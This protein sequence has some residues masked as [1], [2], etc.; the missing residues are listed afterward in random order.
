MLRATLK[1]LLAR[2][3]RLVL[4]MLAVVVGVSFVTGTLVLTDTLNRTFDTLFADINKNVS[5]A[6]RAVNQIDPSSD[7]GRPPL[8]ATVLP[9]LARVDGVR[10]AVGSVSGQAVLVDPR[11]GK[12]AD[13][14]GAPGIGTNWTGGQPTA[15]EQ[16]AE[17]R[18][19]GPGEIV[20]DRAT[21]RSMHLAL[22]TRIV[23]QTK[24]PPGTYTLV[25]TFRV[26]GQDSVGGAAVT[27]FDTATAQRVL[28]APN[29][30]SAVH[31]A[32]APGIG[33]EQLRA[34]VAAVL[35]GGVEAITGK[36][37]A[38]ENAGAVQQAIRGFSTFLLIFAA[39]SVFVGAFIIFNTFTMLVAQRVRELA[40]LRAIG[41]SR[42]QVQLSLQVEAAMVGF[43]G[44]TAGLVVGAGLALLLRAAVG[45]FG[46]SLPGGSL[47]FSPR[48]IVVAY[49][50]GVVIT[51]VAAFVPARKAASV[52]PV[53]AMRETYVLP[54]RSLRLRAISGFAL[55]TL[56]VLLLVLGTA[57]AG[58]SGATSVGVGA[59]AI[60]LGVA[61]LSPL[62]SGPV[63]RVLGTPF[64]SMFGTTGRLGRENAMR[65][66]RRTAST[67]SALMIGLAL[68]SA[69]AILGQ[70]IKESVRATVTDSLGAD[71]YLSA[72][73]F[74]QG[75]SG[76]VAR[77][78]AG[79][80]G[81]DTATGL[82][83]GLAKVDGSS[84]QLLAGDPAGL[85]KVLAIKKV[86]GDIHALGDRTILVE[87]GVA[88]DHHFT[89]GQKIRVAF[90]DG[91]EDLTLVGTY[92]K[93]QVA[94]SWIISTAQYARHTPDDLDLFVLVKRAD[95]A[96]P[97]AV[98]AQIDAVVKPFATVE[99]RDQS[100]FV[101][102][103]EK[104]VDQL[105]GFIYVLLALAVV[106]ALF[107]I[108]N[109]LALSVIERTREIGLLRAVGMSRGQMRA[110]VVMESTIISVFGAV[111]GVAVGSVFGWA[112][113]RALEGQGI[114]AFAYPASTII[115]VILIGVLLGILAAV[116]PA[117]R[118][119]RMDVLRAISTA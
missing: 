39:I 22:G 114:T 84:V 57:S 100:E 66:P 80:P 27:A 2:K 50:V 16:I 13:G 15:S 48:T 101:A 102:Q 42:R 31:L 37:L 35:P 96:S 52:P 17:G 26:A 79:K 103:Q 49:A 32:A 81:I 63:I 86:S 5:V 92:K 11:T 69:F 54:S 20:V 88:A 90:P 118:A 47:V 46:V 105:L 25:G 36:Q 78:L 73:G 75:F 108:V 85:L 10:A 98:R 109:T 24:G 65:N 68:V 40:L 99:V 55:S 6:V 107:G 58:K 4:S 87:D 97:A 30:F 19:P 28:L 14:G 71:F 115:V 95:G 67:A 56:G 89:V 41:A 44:A 59:A 74:G 53:A 38:D 91:S 8:P 106:I 33:Q 34:R 77:D 1:S 18:A 94:G 119:A 21:A 93:S 12:A 83:G 62:L 113:T 45:A 116:F 3:V 111:L 61:T 7:N 9:A 70:S 64:V 60:F 110:M 51:S 76:Q 72:K 29:E 23:V 117:R 112:L 104:Q 82:R 43:A